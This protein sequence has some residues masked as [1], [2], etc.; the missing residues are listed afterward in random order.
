MKLR[1]LC[2]G[3]L[4]ERF[5]AEAVEEFSKRLSRYCE[6]EITELADEKVPENPSPADVDR[7]KAIECRRIADKLSPQDHVIA[8]DPRGKALSSEELSAVL[9]D[10]MLFGRS[11]ITFIIG[12]SHG[13]T[14]ELRSRA[15]LVLSFSKMTFSHQIFRV[16]LLEQIYRAFKILKGEPYHK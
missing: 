13:L 11:R 8:L 14:Q 9:G 1:I 2:V 15:D 4:K 3:K 5:Y 7:V 12:G 10:C 16:M 6:L